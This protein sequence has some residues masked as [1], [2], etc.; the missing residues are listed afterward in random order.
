M[1]QAWDLVATDVQRYNA[2]TCING[3]M[4]RCTFNPYNLDQN[5]VGWVF[6]YIMHDKMFLPKVLTIQVYRGIA[7]AFNNFP[8]ILECTK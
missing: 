8:M 4:S 6:I 5:G 1:L 3:T 2:W 7:S